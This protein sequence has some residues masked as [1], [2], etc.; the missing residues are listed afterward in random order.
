M[1]YIQSWIS[2]IS[3]NIQSWIKALLENHLLKVE[4]LKLLG[5]GAFIGCLLFISVIF[6][7]ESSQIKR[8]SFLGKNTST[9]LEILL[10]IG[11]FIT[12]ILI[13]FNT[14]IF[15]VSIIFVFYLFF[16]Y[17]MNRARNYFYE[18]TR[19]KSKYQ[20]QII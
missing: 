13:L 19:P 1:N 4:Y 16:A 20:K 10:T 17:S 11:T 8:T 7:M 12:L 5:I 6:I 3:V 2:N 9:Y 14:T 15:A 18:K